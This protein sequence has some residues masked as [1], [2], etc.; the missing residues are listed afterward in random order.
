M[1]INDLG[2]NP[3]DQ[4]VLSE[5]P[6]SW[7]Q[8]IKDKVTDASGDREFNDYKEGLKKDYLRWANLTQGLK[9]DAALG[10]KE[11]IA[12]WLKT[13]Y[14][15]SDGEL[16]QAG[17]KAPAEDDAQQD[18]GQDQNQQQQQNQQQGQNQNQQQNQQQQ[19]QQQGQNQNQQQQQPA[20]APKDTA[21]ADK[22]KANLAANQ[23]ARQGG[24]NSM[25]LN[26]WYKDFQADQ[27]AAGKMNLIKEL[28]NRVADYGPKD[29]D[30]MKAILKRIRND[31][32]IGKQGAQFIDSALARMG[33]G[34]DMALTPQGNK[35][36]T[37][38]KGTGT[39]VQRPGQPAFAKTPV[40]NSVMYHVNAIVE[41]LGYTLD[42]LG[43]TVIKESAT[44]SI[45]YN[46]AMLTEAQ[47][48]ELVPNSP[49]PR[50]SGGFLGRAAGA[51]GGAVGAAKGAWQ[52][53]KDA[54][55][56]SKTLGQNQERAHQAGSDLGA[57]GEDAAEN[58]GQ[59]SQQA[60][61]QAGQK[62]QA[63]GAGAGGGDDW[64]K[65]TR[66]MYSTGRLE[67]NPQNNFANKMGNMM[68]KGT[69]F[70]MDNTKGMRRG[71]FGDST[72]GQQGQGGIGGQVDKFIKAGQQSQGGGGG[73]QNTPPQDTQDQNQNQG[74]QQDQNQNQQQGQ[75]GQQGQN[76]NQQ[77]QGGQ[78]GQ[79]QQQGQGGQQDQ[80]GEDTSKVT[81]T[82]DT[83]QLGKV[84][85]GVDA[86]KLSQA[87]SAM[88]SGGNVTPQQKAAMGDAMI[89]LIK[90][91]AAT[92]TKVMNT[93]N[94]ISADTGVASGKTTAPTES[95]ISR[96]ARLMTEKILSKA[97]T[98]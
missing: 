56:G 24:G 48:M 9:G 95:A 79:N 63:P 65:I 62:G 71:G 31:Q 97:M 83:N 13:Q 17:L 92:T 11:T 45:I 32:T 57:S 41:A 77:G 55:Q 89:A 90:A 4:Y 6:G 21:Q 44:T 82:L 46:R 67:T 23:A 14:G 87:I 54:Y 36:A 12:L 64:D 28:V 72:G 84:L 26:K 78:Q 60:K 22:I 96:K 42:Q 38:P 15:L 20:P 27:T 39:G 29:V 86:A 53:A 8:G 7:L 19:N 68:L 85:P 47:I 59:G 52:G 33:Q 49:L 80:G 81:G 16:Q 37:P 34:K 25:D 93:L 40:T 70:S 2:A 94:K 5:G 73:G 35:P 61:G 98:K 74:G 58:P 1:K 30:S 69:P 3:F 76:Q 75:G 66:L 50:Q 91:D 18:Q 88:K 10:N 51:L 43:Y